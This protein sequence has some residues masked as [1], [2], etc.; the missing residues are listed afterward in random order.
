MAAY[1]MTLHVSP[2]CN[3]KDLP[4]TCPTMLGSVR[5]C[6][7]AT[8][9]S[10][11]VEEAADVLVFFLRAENSDQNGRTSSRARTKYNSHKTSVLTGALFL[12][13]PPEEH[14]VQ[15][16]CGLSKDCSRW[17]YWQLPFSFGVQWYGTCIFSDACK[18]HLEQ[19]AIPLSEKMSVCSAY[20]I[21]MCG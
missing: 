19:N 2:Y 6:C 4:F 11:G 13:A 15:W 14:R 20:R 12:S 18:V 3:A 9:S 21:P 5:P 16:R 7:D 1:D 17:N 8:V 10:F